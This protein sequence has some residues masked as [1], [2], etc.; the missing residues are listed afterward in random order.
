MQATQLETGCAYEWYENTISGFSLCQAYFTGTID[1]E[2]DSDQLT[3]ECWYLFELC[4][5]SKEI[6]LSEQELKTLNVKLSRTID[7]DFRYV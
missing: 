5:M 4:D 1:Q 7:K 6:W 2:T 3:S